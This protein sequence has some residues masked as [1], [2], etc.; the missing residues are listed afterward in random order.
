MIGPIQ[1]MG[2]FKKLS[3]VRKLSLVT[4]PNILA[5]QWL[6]QPHLMPISSIALPL[7][8]PSLHASTSVTTPTDWYSKNQATAETDKYGSEF[9]AAKTTTEQIM[10]LRYT[11]KYLGVPINSKSYMFGDNRSVVTSATLP[12]ST[13]SKRHNIVAFH[14]VREAI[15][16]KIIDCHWIKSKYHLSEC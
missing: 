7:V 9:V 1:I 13:L 14:R 8:H 10:D 15:A 2:M 4:A 16:P 3:L 6:P 5:N 12:L 11:L